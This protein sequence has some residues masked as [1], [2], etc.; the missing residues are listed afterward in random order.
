LR[1]FNAICA[2]QTEIS[3]TVRVLPKS[4]PQH[5]RPTAASPLLDQR[6]FRA[7]C[8]ARAR[9]YEVG[10]LNLIEAVDAL[11]AFAVRVE[12]IT[13]L[14]QDAVQAIM[15][16]AFEPVP[17]VPTEEDAEAP[18]KPELADIPLIATHGVPRA[19]AFQREYELRIKRQCERFGPAK[20]MADASEYLAR[21]NSQRLKAWLL[22]HSPAERAAIVSHLRQKQ[23]R[24]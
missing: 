11:Q 2:A 9:L 20:S 24:P 8:E 18:P 5:N 17:S 13:S 4:A 6:I 10:Q 14:G 23:D 1:E 7:R 16:A 19:A 3:S 15:A 12:L 22:E 21:T